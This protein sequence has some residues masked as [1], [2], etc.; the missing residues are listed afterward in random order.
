MTS[1]TSLPTLGVNWQTVS[2]AQYADIL[3]QSSTDKAERT[4]LSNGTQVAVSGHAF[5]NLLLKSG[6]TGKPLGSEET[7]QLKNMISRFRAE[8][9]QEFVVKHTMMQDGGDAPLATMDLSAGEFYHVE[10][11]DVRMKSMSHS[12][13]VE[14]EHAPVNEVGLRELLISDDTS[15]DSLEDMLNAEKE[16][17]EI[18]G[19]DIKVSYD[20]YRDEIV[21][22]T[23]DDLGYRQAKSGKDALDDLRLALAHP[24]SDLDR[25]RA[26]RLIDQFG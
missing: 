24:G 1:T 25:D 22:L 26:E 19:D 5:D 10:K 18:Y 7:E 20:T 2:A 21:M 17:K 6:A 14:L 3:R 9:S 16:L 15:M 8:N 11:P 4:T 12:R 23:P 13:F